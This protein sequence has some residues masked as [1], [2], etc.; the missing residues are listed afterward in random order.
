[1]AHTSLTLMSSL[2]SADLLAVFGIRV[3][4]DKGTSAGST[5]TSAHFAEEWEASRNVSQF[6]VSRGHKA[7]LFTQ[8]GL[9]EVKVVTADTFLWNMWK[10]QIKS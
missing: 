9:A 6:I 8:E 5:H 1:M 4:P 2:A 3:L 7:T 10:G